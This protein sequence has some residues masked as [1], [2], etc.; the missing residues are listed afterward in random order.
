MRSLAHSHSKPPT[1]LAC[2]LQPFSILCLPTSP[3]YFHNLTPHQ[4]VPE[5]ALLFIPLLVC[6]RPNPLPLSSPPSSLSSV[7]ICLFCFQGKS[8]GCGAKSF[9]WSHIF[10][11]WRTLAGRWKQITTCHRLQ[12]PLCFSRLL[13]PTP[14]PEET[15]ADDKDLLQGEE[16]RGRERESGRRGAK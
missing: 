4:T 12:R 3:S 11:R 8:G 13:A 16:E 9:L 2:T 14:F 7:V 6:P 1:G 10:A 5:H 15:H